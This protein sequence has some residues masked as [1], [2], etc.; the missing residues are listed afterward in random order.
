[1][2]EKDFRNWL[3]NFIEE[4]QINQNNTFSYR[5]KDG[6]NRKISVEQILDYIDNTDNEDAKL[7]FKESLEKG[8][9]AD[10]IL[11]YMYNAARRFPIEEKAEVREKAEV[12]TD[13]WFKRNERMKELTTKAFE[14]LE[15]RMKDPATAKTAVKTYNEFISQFK[16]LYNYSLNNN[17]LIFG[18]MQSRNLP[19]TG[20][21]KSEKDWNLLNI[22]VDKNSKPLMIYVPLKSPVWE[23]ETITDE[24]GK[25]K[26]I[27][28]LDDDGKKIQKK[29]ED[30][31]PQYTTN[32]RL[33]G[34]VFDVSQTDAFEKGYKK[35]IN[36]DIDYIKT[37][38]YT[39]SKLN[40]IAN[41]ISS[42]MNVTI[43]FEPIKEAQLGYYNYSGGEHKIFVDNSMSVEKQLSVL[44]HELGHRIIHNI[45]NKKD[46]NKEIDKSLARKEAE[47]ES[48]AY[49]VGQQF[50][51]DTPS[52]EYI[53]PYIQG[54]DVKLKDIFEDVF[55]AVKNFNDKV[56]MKPMI[57]SF[58]K[59]DNDIDNMK[60]LIDE[61][62]E[63]DNSA[64]EDIK[65]EMKQKDKEES[66]QSDNQ[67]TENK[68]RN[69]QR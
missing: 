47:A 4:S 38:D 67:K 13:S 54:T 16:N 18:Q 30:G 23:T 19:Y 41:E 51:I 55:K 7:K 6:S 33:S 37:I 57:T 10:N 59:Y 44:L 25:P 61:Y 9:E 11:G 12:E 46:E 64:I 42:A 39:K 31:K 35:A 17:Q 62:K 5:N 27:V 22:E 15:D 45:D 21:I 1:M 36:E 43:K 24:N 56:Q 8:K 20:V 2:E 40:I 49:V 50:G 52:G 3:I 29:D 53:L 32:F 34:K 68:N 65:E 14:R 48:F 26:V 58:I 66:K 28:K 60:K 69:R 63:I